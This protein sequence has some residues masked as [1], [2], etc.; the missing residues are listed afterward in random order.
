MQ[1]R[2]VEIEVNGV[3]QGVGFR[4]FVARLASKYALNGS[5]KNS[6][7][8]ALIKL[9]ADETAISH[10][11]QELK[12]NH[13]VL[14]KIDK[15]TIKET[16]Y[17]NFE[18]FCVEESE[19]GLAQSAFFPPD[20]TICDECKEELFA[21]ANRRFL[22]PLINCQNCGPR[23]TVIQSLP[24]DRSRTTM[25]FFEMCDECKSEYKNISNR[26]FHAEPISCPNCGPTMYF[27]DA[28][29][30]VTD[31]SKDGQI[32]SCVVQ[33]LREGKIVAIKGVGGFH[34]ICRADR[35]EAVLR[36]REKKRRAKK[37]L[38]VM[39]SS[40]EALKKQC[41]IS[42]YEEEMISSLQ[43]PI[44]IVK[45][46]TSY[47][48][49]SHISHESGFVGVFLPYN[50]IYEILFSMIDFALVATSANISDEPIETCEKAIFARLGE[51][52][53]YA[54][55]YDRVIVQECDDSVVRA[56]GDM[57]IKLRN[58]RGYAPY[59]FK[60][61]SFKN[62]VFCAG[63]HQ[64]NCFAFCFDDNIA[65]SSHIGDLGSLDAQEYYESSVLH[66]KSLWNLSVDV[67][68]RDKNSRYASSSFAETFEAKK[69]LLQHHKAHFLALL[70]EKQML[71]SDAIGV[72]WDGTGVG[73]D[74]NI[75]G[76]EVFKKSG[77]E[78]QRLYHLP[79]FWLLGGE[80]MAKQPRK[81]ALS[82]AL[83]FLN[84]KESYDVAKKLGF[85]D[86]EICIL[87]DAFAK[88]TNCV[89]S[90]SMGRLFDAVAALCGIV[91]EDCYEGESGLMIESLY[92]VSIE[93]SFDGLS[94]IGSILREVVNTKSPS[95]VAS[96][97]I[98]TLTDYVKEL[99]KKHQLPIFCSGGVFQ[100]ATLVARIRAKLGDGAV[101]FHE[102]LS[103]NDSSICLGQAA[104]ASLYLN[105]HILQEEL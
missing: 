67:V 24:Y 104:F 88:K 84:E 92:D 36:L 79:E 25:R 14:A 6:P 96:K 94:D 63:A 82:I 60:A 33:A 59:F 12:T 100:N 3:V 101:F 19:Q 69:L 93:D 57:M 43:R 48:L 29:G 58:S 7:S 89:K 13:P 91:K 44:T 73:D 41:E 53:D 75:W 20:L 105:G 5:V 98:N 17:Q 8:G 9:C 54:L 37:P 62:Q 87:F 38:A 51:A 71:H 80:G 78:L 64:K 10:F 40:M 1:D 97:F 72:V 2:C 65:I 27:A 55:Y 32:L 61:E 102:E 18:G 86:D 15:I 28:L 31:S 68:V 42:D 85:F 21:P 81:S 47:A 77:Y 49:S 45:K 39:F 26:R 76:G 23:F 11:V 30:S 34:L 22:Y 74:G 90:T 83:S 35:D 99:S 4:P 103:P 46:S 66:M 16:P 50:G 95:I 56:A 52:F 70:F